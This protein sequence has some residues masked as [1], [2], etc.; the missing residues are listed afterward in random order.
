MPKARA[1]LETAK[2]IIVQRMSSQPPSA[3]ALAKH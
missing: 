3:N 1:L 2:K